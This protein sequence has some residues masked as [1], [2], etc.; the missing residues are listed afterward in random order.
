MVTILL[1]AIKLILVVI[2]TTFGNRQ[3]VKG[4]IQLRERDS[5]GD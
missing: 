4:Q 2:L 3:K 5:G 1:I